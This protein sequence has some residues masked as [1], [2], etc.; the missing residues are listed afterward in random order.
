MVVW[1]QELESRT[2]VGMTGQL[3]AA[4]VDQLETVCEVVL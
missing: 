4:G 1:F 2:R 3:L